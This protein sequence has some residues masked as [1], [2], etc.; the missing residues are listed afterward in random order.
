ML[1]QCS[2]PHLVSFCYHQPRVNTRTQDTPLI[3]VPVLAHLTRRQAPSW[4]FALLVGTPSSGDD[5]R[6]RIP[7][8]FDLA[9]LW[10]YSVH[11][12]VF[13]GCK[14]HIGRNSE[15][16]TIL[17]SSRLLSLLGASKR[18]RNSTKLRAILAMS[19]AVRPG[20]FVMEGAEVNMKRERSLYHKRNHELCSRPL[21]VHS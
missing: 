10:A 19:F 1:F 11:L 4:Q 12:Q 6:L 16:C 8:L 14:D 9:I 7:L 15:L 17:I 21:V 3:I 2:E 13:L 18:S 20:D 5:S